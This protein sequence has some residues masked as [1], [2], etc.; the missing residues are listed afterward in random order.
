MTAFSR[1]SLLKGAAAAAALPAIAPKLAFANTPT[2]P[3]AV[4]IIDLVGG[5]NALF[6]S[7]A[8]FV[9]AGTF[10]TSAGTVYQVPGTPPAGAQPLSIDA[11]TLG[12]LPSAALGHIATLGVNHHL[13]AH[14]S[15]RLALWNDPT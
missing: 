15:A 8:S 5:Y 12:T 10:G 1:R 9:G 11:P 13:S 6:G 14:T 2:R 7:A 3:T 4:V